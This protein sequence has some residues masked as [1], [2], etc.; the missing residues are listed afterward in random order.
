MINNKLT[1]NLS[2][3]L[4]LLCNELI[5]YVCG[6]VL[7]FLSMR[8]VSFAIVAIKNKPSQ[9]TITELFCM[10]QKLPETWF[11]CLLW[12]LFWLW[13]LIQPPHL[14]SQMRQQVHWVAS[15][16]GGEFCC[17]IHKKSRH[18]NSP[19]TNLAYMFQI[20][21]DVICT[22]LVVAVFSSAWWW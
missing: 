5:W 14:R 21:W 8:N 22:S 15:L 16:G 11:S 4:M 10:C 1:S 13:P 20:I 6:V 2:L 19:F 3:C 7:H 18:R 12:W 17:W 9:L